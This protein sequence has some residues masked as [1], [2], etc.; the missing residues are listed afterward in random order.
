MTHAGLS[1][2]EMNAVFS[3]NPATIGRLVGAARPAG[4]AARPG[5]LAAA[6]ADTTVVVVVL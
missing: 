2:E 5:G 3:K 6:D 1:H 4:G